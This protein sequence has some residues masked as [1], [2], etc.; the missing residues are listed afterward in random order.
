[1]LLLMSDGFEFYFSLKRPFR[2]I[3][4][5]CIAHGFGTR[6]NFWKPPKLSQN[7]YK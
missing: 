2:A 7:P 3:F 4:V 1:M 5:S 6:A